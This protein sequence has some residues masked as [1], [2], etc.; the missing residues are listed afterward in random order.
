MD[1]WI[2]EFR[3]L[4]ERTSPASSV[5]MGGRAVLIALIGAMPML[6]SAGELFQFSADGAVIRGPVSKKEI[7]LVFTG[8]EFAEGVPVIL[9]Q[10]GRHGGK[11]SF[12]LTGDFLANSNHAT[13]AAQIVKEG[14][15]LGPH[16]DKHLLYCSWESSKKTLVTREEFA[17][18]VG[19]NLAKIERLGVARSNVTFFLP[20]FEHC[21]AEIVR[22]SEG[23]GLRM[24]NYTPG[25]RSN[26]DYTGEAE[27]NFVSAR[28]IY[29]SIVAKE[30]S[31]P[32]GLNGFILLLHI[33][34]GPG[35]TDKFHARF[36]ELLDYLA[37]RGYR[38]VRVD[39]LLASK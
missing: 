27:P 12:S 9:E 7:A 31:D 2:N 28:T 24:I 33:G 16:S 15:Y 3:N 10:L 21:N 30:K 34:A 36:G 29:D 39:E 5:G 35:R 8:H 38:F 37:G 22:W 17:E 25:T 18:D 1:W 19:R 14:H 32:K 20:P 23:M 4:W 11:A 13:L 26:A 6:V